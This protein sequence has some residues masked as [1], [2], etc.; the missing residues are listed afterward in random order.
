MDKA[1]AIIGDEMLN[2]GQ[3]PS[4]TVTL[5]LNESTAQTLTEEEKVEVI[6]APKYRLYKRRFVGAVGVFMLDLLGGLNPSWFGPISNSGM[7]SAIHISEKY[8][9]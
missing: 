4:V 9:L 6:A 2:E 5:P 8:L 1:N 3:W 7:Y